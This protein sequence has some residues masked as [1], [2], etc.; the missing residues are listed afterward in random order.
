MGA[1][2]SRMPDCTPRREFA[3][4]WR[5]TTLT[6]S[7]ITLRLRGSTSIIRPVLPLS[8]PVMTTTRSFF[9]TLISTFI[10]P[11]NHFRREADDLHESLVAQLAGD[12]AEDARAHR[13]I[14]RL[15]DHR[16]VLI[17]ANIRA[18]L[19]ARLFARADDD[20]AHDLALLDRAIGRCLFD[21]R[22][23]DNA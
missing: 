9:R 16:G 23:D 15:D 10:T 13:L 11:S 6:P 8:L 22:R 14:V 20:G 21:R 12:G 17:K 5:L 1:S 4:V 7:T 18:V 2:R 3:L 19:A